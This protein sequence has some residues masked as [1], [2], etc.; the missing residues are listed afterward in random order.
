MVAVFTSGPGQTFVF[1]VF[2]DP[3]LLDTGMSRTELSFL[4]SVGTV[5]SAAMSL[6]MSHLVGKFGPRLMMGLIAFFFGAAC[7]GISW[8][9]GSVGFLVFFAALRALGQGSL[10][11]TAILLAVQWFVRY[12]GRA[13]GLVS[14]GMAAANKSE[15][16]VHSH[17]HRALE[18]GATQ[19]EIEH[20][21]LLGIT[22]LGFPNMMM[23][24]TW[25]RAAIAAH[26]K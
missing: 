5:F 16:A 22:T 11:M 2:V 26:K 18:A 19:A 6:A 4:Y 15:T 21:V 17:T 24:L 8:A 14:L 7:F 10:T 20:A 23:A 13:M 9:N 1:S 25:C 3:I 12:R